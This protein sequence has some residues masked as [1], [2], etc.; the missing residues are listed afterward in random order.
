MELGIAMFSYSILYYLRD[1]SGYERNSTMCYFLE[2]RK[3]WDTYCY[4]WCSRPWSSSILDRVLDGPFSMYGEDLLYGS[5]CS[6]LLS[7]S[8]RLISGLLLSHLWSTWNCHFH[9]SSTRKLGSFFSWN[10]KIWILWISHYSMQTSL[11]FYLR[12]RSANEISI[13]SA[14]SNNQLYA[15]SKYSNQ[16]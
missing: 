15:A 12:I 9:F 1:L 13:N 16:L 6:C 4:V 5:P 3:S 2:R 11:S 8:R 14:F 10:Q 7:G